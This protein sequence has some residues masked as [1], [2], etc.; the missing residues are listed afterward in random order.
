[1]RMR[2]LACGLLVLPFSGVVRRAAPDTWHLFLCSPLHR[3]YAGQA[4]PEQGSSGAGPSSSAAAAAAGA[5]SSKLPSAGSSKGKRSRAGTTAAGAGSSRAAEG[6]GGP[7]E[8][9]DP[10]TGELVS[11][12]G[13]WTCQH[14]TLRNDNTAAESCEVCGLPRWDE[15]DD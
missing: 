5:S 9:T 10:V 8:E 6:L 7:D 13:Y 3:R 14:C 12:Q 1:L 15:D 4:A 2:V 11:V